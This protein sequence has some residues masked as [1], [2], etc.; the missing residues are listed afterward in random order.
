MILFS[1]FKDLQSFL[2]IN[3]APHKKRGLVPTMGA[4]HD[5]HFS[6]IAQCKQL[7]DLT[8]CS[9]FVNP[10]QFNNPED[11]KKYPNTIESD[12][13]ALEEHECDVLLLP[14][15]EEVYPDD[16]SKNKTYELGH[17]ENILEGKFRPG[18]FQGVCLV[19]ERLLRMVE[20]DVLFLGQKDFQQCMVIKEL[21]SQLDQDIE[22]VI[23]P[24]LREKSGLAMS[25]RNLR[26]N[27]AE[28]RTAALLYQSLCI[29]KD[30]LQTNDF[31]QLR[32]AAVR[33]LETSGFQVDYLELAKSDNLELTNSYDPTGQ[34][35]I[36]IAAYLNGV[37]LIDNLLIG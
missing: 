36:L 22:I 9:L 4:L 3:T 26:L 33:K 30:S 25:S 21:V 15:Y 27:V 19:V 14:S 24:T 34:Y 10:L 29:I 28:K 6:L 32:D 37:R 2:N 17:L 5:G 8:V 31:Q 11:F 1:H 35:V 7:T 12:I 16:A 18:H 23:C 20:P 13:L